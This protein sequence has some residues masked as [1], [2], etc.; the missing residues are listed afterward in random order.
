MDDA[1]DEVRILTANTWS[2]FALAVCYWRTSM[3]EM[4]ETLPVEDKDRCAVVHPET[5]EVIEIDIESGHFE[6]IL[7]GLFIHLD[8]TNVRLQVFGSHVGSYL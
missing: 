7:D 8:D 2:H 1:K 4:K 6:T 3:Q 5:K